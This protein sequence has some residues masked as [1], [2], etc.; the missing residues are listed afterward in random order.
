MAW[1][2]R[3]IE[4]QLGAALNAPLKALANYLGLAESAMPVQ[5]KVRT[6]DATV[7]TLATIK[8]PQDNSVLVSGFVVARRTGGSAG[9]ANDGAGYAVEFVATNTTGTAAQIGA[10]VVTVLGESQ[11][12][13]NVTLAVSGINALVQVT[14]AVN[15]NVTWTWSGRSLTVAG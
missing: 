10:G 1:D 2:W 9:A 5:Q 3:P 14:G 13:W 7:T 11:A 15:N 4:G 8:I 6:T 12:G